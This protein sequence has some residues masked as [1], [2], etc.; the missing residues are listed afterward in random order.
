M[1]TLGRRSAALAATLATCFVG[2]ATAAGT[3]RLDVFP[4]RPR[5]GEIATIELRTYWTF[6]DRTPPAVFAAD[7]PMVVTAFATTGRRFELRLVRDNRDRH[8]WRGDFRFP[9]RGRWTVCGANLQ[10]SLQQR[11]STTNRTRRNV[12]VRSRHE[13]VDVWHRLQRPMVIPSISDDG[14]CPG[15]PADGDLRGRGWAG[16]AWGPGPAYPVGLADGPILYYLDPIPRSS[17]FFGSPWFGNKVLWF[18]DRSVYRGPV[19]IRGRRLDGPHLLRFDDGR[20]PPRELRIS[21]TTRQNPSYTRVS[22]PG[23]YAYQVDGLGFSYAIVFRAGP[24]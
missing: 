23:C 10:P 7:Y 24:F 3:A 19:L 1:R 13:K 2:D 4:D 12:P 14:T 6:P 17:V 22:A 20:T 15:A 18:V 16:A 8:L 9:T 11:C 5:A 21:A